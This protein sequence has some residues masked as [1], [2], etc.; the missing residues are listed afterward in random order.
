MEGPDGLKAFAKELVSAFS[1][2]KDAA[3]FSVVSFAEDATTRVLW[4]DDEA[5]I[6]AGVDE[7]DP[8]GSTSISDGIVAA[9]QLFMA[10]Q[11]VANEG[12]PAATKI[13]LLLSDGE[14]TTDKAPGKTAMQTAVDA[15]ALARAEGITLF[16]WGFGGVSESTLRQIAS[17]PSKAIY[18][19]N[20]AELRSYLADLQVA[21]CEVKLPPPSPPPPPASPSPPPALPSPPPPPKSPR[22]PTAVDFA[23][24]LDESGS[25]E[26]FMEGPDGLKA[27]AKE[28]VSAFSVGKDAAQFSVVSFE[29]DATTR[30]LWSDDEAE[31]GAGIDEM[32]P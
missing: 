22:C 21:A 5:E 15:A 7:M 16:A 28:L 27:F 19:T 4:S 8:R 12:R 17:D 2:G 30:V 10:R 32:D 29:E 6:G 20:L 14:Q 26:N 23:L 31:I 18:A 25:M 3:Q 9:R 1:V 24:V 13:V 11:L